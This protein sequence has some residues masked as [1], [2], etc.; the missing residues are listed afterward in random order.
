MSVGQETASR[1]TVFLMVAL[2]FA[3]LSTILFELALTRIFSIVLWYDYAFMA[4]S[5]AFFGLGAGSLFVH[6]RKDRASNAQ[7]WGKLRWLALPAITTANSTK[8]IVGYSVAYAISVPI[9]LVAITQIPPDPSYIYMFYLVST[10]PFFFVGSIMALIFYAM[11]KNINKLYF[12]D[13]IGASIAAL[14]LD[15]LMMRLGAESVLLSTSL[16]VLGPVVIGGFLLQR[17]GSEKSEGTSFVLTRRVRVSSAGIFTAVIILLGLA[18]PIMTSATQSPTS[19]GIDD[20]LKVHPGPNKGLYWQ[21]KHPEQFE[22]LT[23]QWN[24]FSRIDITKT[25]SFD[26]RIVENPT[27]DDAAIRSSRELASI[28]IDADAGTPI[29]KW[30]GYRD[31]LRWM[32]Q[33]MDFLPYEIIN[34]DHSLV[35][36][37]GGGQDILMAL[38]GGS[39]KVTA[40]E[41]NPNIVAAVRSFGDQAGNVYDRPEVELHIDDGRRFI[42]SS[43]STYDV[44]TIKLVDSWAAQL[45]GGYALSENYLYTVEAFQQYIRHL[46]DGGML[47]MIRWNFELPRLMPIVAEAL[48]RET[49]KDISQVSDH[50]I[51]VEDRPGLYFGR[52]SDSQSYYPVLVMVKSEPF[53]GEQLNFVKERAAVSSADVI[54]LGDTY[55]TPPYDD[56]FSVGGRED[57]LSYV[58]S[59]MG[60]NTKLPTDDSPFYFSREPVP[61]QMITLLATVLAISAGLSAVV[62]YHAR[63]ASTKRVDGETLAQGNEKPGAMRLRYFVMFAAFI[64]LGFMILEITFIQK[65]LLLLGTPIMALTVILFSILLSSGIGAYVSG[66]FFRDRPYRAVFVSIPILAGVILFHLF[67]LQTIIDSS[68]SQELPLRAAL[69]FGLLFPPGLLMGFQFPSLIRMATVEG[70]SSASHTVSGNNTTLLWGVNIIASIIGTVLAALLAMLIGFNG[71]LMIGIAMYLGAGASAIMAILALRRSEKTVPVVSQD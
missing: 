34:A 38:A 19:Y 33:Y 58:T 39:E 60:I 3:S 36:G 30:G 56:L 44:I 17:A 9:F 51:V 68:I 54:M 69:T 6:I 45:A 52:E 67:S 50:L 32:Q 49:G 11:P 12:A 1:F 53:T 5:V 20:L 7:Q 26:E 43:T 66:K 35:I 55:A 62:I 18:N 2:F 24:S 71:N 25:L 70:Q 59:V 61:T 47:V 4:I 8:N 65:F 23:T 57:Y 21:L 37:S 10:I 15:P 41:I 29:Y 48:V 27:Y 14:L 31:E 28:L 22:H 64:G 16:M 63:R 40:V 46:D 42:G 13:L